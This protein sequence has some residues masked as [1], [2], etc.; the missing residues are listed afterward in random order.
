MAKS[1]PF[2]LRYIKLKESS[3][4]KKITESKEALSAAKNALYSCEMELQSLLTCWRL[5]DIN[6]KQCDEQMFKLQHCMKK[7]VLKIAYLGK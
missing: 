1:V 4:A 3:I 6:S 5:S 7:M 2:K